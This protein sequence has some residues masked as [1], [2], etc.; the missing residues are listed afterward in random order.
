[1]AQVAASSPC[2]TVANKAAMPMTSTNLGMKRP[3]SIA[4]L[5]TRTMLSLMSPRPITWM[6]TFRTI[7]GR[8]QAQLA[9]HA[10]TSTA[11]ILPVSAVC[12]D[13]IVAHPELSERDAAQEE[14]PC[15][16]LSAGNEC[17]KEQ[18]A[19]RQSCRSII[20]RDPKLSPLAHA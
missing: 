13:L 14:P 19:W 2:S 17:E 9:F 7:N 10:P 11:F 1:M 20:R 6:T 15:L 12:L 3:W 4:L 8:L 16:R 18:P 5:R